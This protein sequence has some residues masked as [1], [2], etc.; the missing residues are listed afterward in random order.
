MPWRVPMNTSPLPSV[1]STAMTESPSSTPIAMMPPARGL[2]NPDSAVFLTDQVFHADLARLGLDDLGPAVVAVLV[3]NR[4]QLVDDDL[5]Q[6]ALARQNGP[7]PLDR[8]EELG[9][10]VENLLPLEAREALQLHVED[11]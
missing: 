6:Q 9:E 1:T 4:L 3:P 8:L 5:H 10:L 11:R 2:L 7:Q